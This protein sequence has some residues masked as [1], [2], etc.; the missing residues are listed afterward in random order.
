MP[1]FTG[2][3]VAALAA[4][5]AVIEKTGRALNVLDLTREYGFTDLD[6]TLPDWDY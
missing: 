4:D 1:W 2:R 6:G 3:A 5:P